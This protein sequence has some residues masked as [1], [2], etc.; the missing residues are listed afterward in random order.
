MKK[1]LVM[2]HGAAVVKGCEKVESSNKKQKL[3]LWP[4]LEKNIVISGKIKT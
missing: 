2:V 4:I 1:Q 3:G